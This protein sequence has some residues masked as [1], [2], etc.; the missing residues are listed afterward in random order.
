MNPPRQEGWFVR[1]WKWFVPV[2]CLSMILM[3][4]GFIAA[5]A[6]LAF[7]SIKSSYV[8]QQAIDKTRSNA[9]S[10]TMDFYKDIVVFRKNDFCQ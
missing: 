10:N 4:V 5:V 7:G 6:Y 9:E 1:N 8:Y 2:G 3:I